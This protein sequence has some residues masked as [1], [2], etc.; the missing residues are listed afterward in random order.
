MNLGNHRLGQGG[1]GQHHLGAAAEQIAEIG[2]A[3]IF[4]LFY[5]ADMS[6][7]LVAGRMLLP[8]RIAAQALGVVVFFGWL[9]MGTG[10]WLGGALFDWTG[11]YFWS[12]AA[13]A[14]G[15]VVNLMIL[16]VFLLNLRGRK[17]RLPEWTEDPGGLASP[18][19]V[20]P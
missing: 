19:M 10:A 9:G 18:G 6:T 11:D 20:R 15:G 12:Y 5:S 4:G 2:L 1:N 8:A 14:A 16:S 17:V 7:I 3:A 13:A